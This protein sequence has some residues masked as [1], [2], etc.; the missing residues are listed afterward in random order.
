MFVL[1]PEKAGL[2]PVPH[3]GAWFLLMT[4]TKS[5]L[6]PKLSCTAL[7][8]LVLAMKDKCQIVGFNQDRNCK[9]RDPRAHSMNLS[10]GFFYFVVL[11]F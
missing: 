8:E 1:P 3:L 6:S 7:A 10:L 11:S 9:C 4:A 5:A 2:S